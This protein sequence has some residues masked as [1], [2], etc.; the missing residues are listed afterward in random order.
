MDRMNPL[1]AS[2]LAI[3]DGNNPMHIGSV[4][5]FEGP[6]PTYGDVVR[7]VASKLPLVP[8]YRQKVRMVPFQLGRPVWVDDPNF[9]ILYHIRHTAVPKP[10]S[11]DQLRNVAGRVFAQNLDRAKPLWEMWI[12]EGLSDDRW[13]LISK[14]HHSMVDGVSGADLLQVI[15]DTSPA[16][17]EPVLEE[18]SPPREPSTIEV[19]ADATVD[20]ILAPLDALRGL[21]AFARSPLPGGMT[22]G[23]VG[24]SLQAY[25]SVVMG[26]SVDLNGPIGPHRRW[27][28]AK[29][30]LAD[31]KTI[32]TALPGTVNDVVLAVITSGFRDLLQSRGAELEGRVVRTL[33]PV[34]VRSAA[35]QGVH[36]NRVSG[37]FPGLPVGIE[38]PVER[39]EEIRRQMD[40]LKESKM[41]V[42]GDSLVKMG[43]F[44]PPMLLALGTRLASRMPQRTVNTITTNVPG[45]QIPL[46][47]QGRQMI[48][49]YPYVPIQGNVRIAIAIFSYLGGM[50]FGVTGDYDSTADID[51]LTR[52]IEAGM[53]EYLRIA[54]QSGATPVTAAPRPVTANAGGARNRAA[55]RRRVAPA[56]KRAKSATPG[57]GTL[58]EVVTSVT[59]ASA[60]GHSNGHQK[61]ALPARKAR[62]SKKPPG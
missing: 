43:G 57:S 14:V 48:E 29:G 28:W 24:R 30:S 37:T 5:T 1:D 41:A 25:G 49:A 2:F 20:R 62:A 13:A 45:P 19:L 52:G 3:E 4:A 34:S 56:G 50:N 18:W 39:L 53:Q 10:G 47:I 59:P 61:G 21:P 23:D 32:R 51:V 27:S 31:I 38:D 35:E 17:T 6:A 11:A 60:N 7:M 46:Y 33:V 8:R 15:L 36:N 26:K 54:A 40:G 55:S 44:A 9:Q 22:L 16:V 12:V 42:A 58:M